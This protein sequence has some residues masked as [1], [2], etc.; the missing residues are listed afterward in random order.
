MN[1]SPK[2]A[3]IFYVPV[4]PRLESTGGIRLFQIGILRD[5]VAYEE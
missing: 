1:L 4:A 5:D 3:A 2:G